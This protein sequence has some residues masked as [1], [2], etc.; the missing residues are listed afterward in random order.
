MHVLAYTLLSKIP[1]VLCT[2]M[3]RM[4]GNAL[5][6]AAHR[7]SS[8]ATSFACSRTDEFDV[9]AFTACLP[10]CVIHASRSKTEP[11]AP[12]PS[13]LQPAEAAAGAS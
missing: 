5:P 1:R 12:A 13:V 7:L 11:S 4:P 8:F 9:D 2:S 6:P 10:A 3:T